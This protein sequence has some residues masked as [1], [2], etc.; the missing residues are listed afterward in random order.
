VFLVVCLSVLT[1]D[2]GIIHW[3]P[4]CRAHK[5]G[6]SGAHKG[7]FPFILTRICRKE[8]SL[9]LSRML[10]YGT[11][12]CIVVAVVRAKGEVRDRFGRRS[13]F[14]PSKAYGFLRTRNRR[15]R[16]TP[17]PPPTNN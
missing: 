3:T 2:I 15:P 4:S 5:I 16:A 13:N 1:R 17:L 12:S 14:S 10:G 7:H 11:F 9:L 6:L 8:T